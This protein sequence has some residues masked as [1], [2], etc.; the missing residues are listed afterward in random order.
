MQCDVKTI[1][2]SVLRLEY[3]HCLCG[4]I[5]EIPKAHLLHVARYNTWNVLFLIEIKLDI[6]MYI[7][8]KNLITFNTHVLIHGPEKAKW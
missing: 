7:K 1:Q 3:K 5:R 2:S 4:N 6:D 8:I